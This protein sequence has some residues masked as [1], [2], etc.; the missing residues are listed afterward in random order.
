M[1]VAKPLGAESLTP[2][3]APRRI[4]VIRTDRI[5]DVILTTPL[6]RE[7]ARRY[8]GAHISFLTSVVGAQLVSDNPLVS[9]ILVDD[10][11][12]RHHGISGFRRQARELDRRKFDAAVIA[13]PMARLAALVRAA[14]IP[15]RIGSGFRW[16]AFLF[17][18]RIYEHRS[19]GPV[20]HEAEHN[21]SL[22]RALGCPVPTRLL[23]EIFLTPEEDQA[24]ES[25]LRGMGLGPTDSVVAVHPGGGGSAPRWPPDRFVLLGDRLAEEGHR[26]FVTGGADEWPLVKAIA[27]SM[28]RRPATVHGDLSLK[29]LTA[30]LARCRLFVSNS[31]GPMH[32]AAVAGVP[33]L[34][35]FSTRRVMSAARWGPLIE[36]R[37]VLTG[38]DPACD[39][40]ASGDCA[41]HDDL[42][43]IPVDQAFAAAR[44]LLAAGRTASQGF[45]VGAPS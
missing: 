1:S 7:I 37:K 42:S 41:R 38:A 4:L 29:P 9:E 12:G 30:A 10:R 36:S 34:T 11:L 31:T 6:F 39:R 19:R 27:A 16:Y 14:R 22:L 20:R 28:R 2:A 44:E 13:H 15:V 5:G 24:G 33:I 35:F 18:R 21:L 3:G 23:P 25:F 8:P 26:I 40:C 17:N 32:L 43:R 45:P